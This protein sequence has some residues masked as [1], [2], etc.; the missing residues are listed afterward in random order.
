[1]KGL[2]CENKEEEWRCNLA[3]IT[4]LKVFFSSE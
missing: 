1:M 4:T 2:S 3:V